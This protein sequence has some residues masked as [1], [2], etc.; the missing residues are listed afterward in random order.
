MST[1]TIRPTAT[2]PYRLPKAAMSPI[3][4]QADVEA[5]TATLESVTAGLGTIAQADSTAVD[6]PGIVADFNTLLANLRTAG[7]LA[8]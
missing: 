4:T 1:L 8:V 7:V 6:V 2:E 5:G 3:A